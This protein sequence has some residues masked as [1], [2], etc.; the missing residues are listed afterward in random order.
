V[1]EDPVGAV[2]QT[3]VAAGVTFLPETEDGV[4]VKG[5]AKGSGSK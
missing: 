2:Y 4:G 5:K 3:L 1:S